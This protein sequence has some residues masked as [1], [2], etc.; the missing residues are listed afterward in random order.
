MCIRDRLDD[1]SLRG[2]RGLL[3]SISGS[4]SLTLYEVDAAAT[5]VR[6]EVDPE[7]N[8]IIGATF[9]DSLGDKLRVSIVASGLA[10]EADAPV[11]GAKLAHAAAS[12]APQPTLPAMRAPEPT[13][14]LQFAPQ[15]QP[16][17]TPAQFA[18]QVA[19][20]QG[21]HGQGGEFYQPPQAVSPDQMGDL[22][23]NGPSDVTIELSQP[24]PA[25]P[26]SHWSAASPGGG[27]F[28]EPA[29]VFRPQPPHENR[30]PGRRMP[31][32]EDF[33]PFAQ[34]AYRAQ[35]PDGASRPVAQ[36]PAP[37]ER[38]RGGL[39]NFLTGRKEDTAAAAESPFAPRRE[40]RAAAPASDAAARE[41]N[42]GWNE[43]QP[44]AEDGHP[45]RAPMPRQRPRQL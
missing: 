24:A 36:A 31:D 29:P 5:R 45:H 10:P 34:D 25:Q 3:V 26:P 2:A 21:W 23:W 7:A 20:S 30:R 22:N 11:R 9:D 12:A 18:E 39:F 38:K 17:M 42:P 37:A 33:S 32:V 28:D 40:T 8:V 16:E 6:Q 43:R 35:R 44:S 19:A 4:R 13:P 14:Q 15:P 27:A 41:N 1:V